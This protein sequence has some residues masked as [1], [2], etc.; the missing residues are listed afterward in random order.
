MTAPIDTLFPQ[1]KTCPHEDLS[2]SSHSFLNLALKK[3][4]IQR[5]IMVIFSPHKDSTKIWLLMQLIKP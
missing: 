1:R 4:N 3:S 5:E 2:F